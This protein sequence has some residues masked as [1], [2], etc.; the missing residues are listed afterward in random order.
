MSFIEGGQNRRQ[1][2]RVLPARGTNGDTLPTLEKTG[3]LDC[4][5]NLRFKSGD[6]VGDTEGVSIFGSFDFG[7]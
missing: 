5:E 4:V 6:E 2:S 1:N 3:G 7:G